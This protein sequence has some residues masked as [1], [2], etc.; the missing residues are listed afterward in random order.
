VISA[1]LNIPP[2]ESL[3][4]EWGEILDRFGDAARRA[5][6]AAKFQAALVGTKLR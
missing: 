6:A 2:S 5:R 1:E 4:W 3:D